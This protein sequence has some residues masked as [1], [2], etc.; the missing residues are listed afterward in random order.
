MWCEL[1]KG[2]HGQ[3]KRFQKP[4]QA[5]KEP[6]KPA[7][8]STAKL[9]RRVLQPLPEENLHIVDNVVPELLGRV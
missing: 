3:R 8:N 5:R 4:W 2:L 9:I 7:F 6:L 1:E